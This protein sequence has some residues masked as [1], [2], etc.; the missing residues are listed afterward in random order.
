[1]L[2]EDV[3]FGRFEELTAMLLDEEENSERLVQSAPRE[4][5]T[6]DKLPFELVLGTLFVRELLED[7]ESAAAA[8]ALLPDSTTFKSSLGIFF[9]VA[10]WS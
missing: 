5:R 7:V 3:D 9:D 10:L 6:S 1:M 2:L 8:E 4:A